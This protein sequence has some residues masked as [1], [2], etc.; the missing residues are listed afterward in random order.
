M[1]EGRRELK[2]SKR[3]TPYTLPPLQLCCLGWEVI[4]LE[5]IHV[6]KCSHINKF[7]IK[8]HM[9]GSLDTRMCLVGLNMEV[10]RAVTFL[11]ETSTL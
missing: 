3:Q 10:L 8:N 7:D 11:A 5:L 4:A 9:E 6:Y 2:I 1:K